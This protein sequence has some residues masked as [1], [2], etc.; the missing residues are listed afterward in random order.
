MLI[1]RLLTV[2]LR[3]YSYI[4]VRIIE[5]TCVD[6]LV[7]FPYFFLN[8]QMY[9]P[10]PGETVNQMKVLGDLVKEMGIRGMYTGIYICIYVYLYV[11]FYMYIY[12]DTYILL[13]R[14]SV[15]W[16]KR[17]V[18][19]ACTLV[20]IYMYLYVYLSMYIYMYTYMYILDI[21]IIMKG[22]W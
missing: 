22:A 2:Y 21:H 9:N 19:G 6:G 1:E 18:S 4:C 5:C 20:H 7:F 11:Y 12:M 15:I 3:A 13:S 14:C 16:L 10:A 8:L 17:W